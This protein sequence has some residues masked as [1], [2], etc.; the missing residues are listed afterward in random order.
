LACHPDGGR[1]SDTE[2]AR[3][4]ILLGVTWLRDAAW[5][6]ITE[7]NL[8]AHIALW[9][10]M[11]RRA[12]I[13]TAATASLLAYAHWLNGDV[14]RA[15]LATERALEADLGYGMAY[16]MIELITHAMPS[17]AVAPAAAHSSGTG[18]PGR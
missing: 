5:L 6:S 17:G 18:R 2:A 11:T 16:L 13:N 1:L 3:L 4:S 7:E 10:D 12:V 9:T 8:S 15:H 14:I